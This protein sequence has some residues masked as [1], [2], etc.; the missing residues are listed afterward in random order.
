MTA[1]SSPIVDPEFSKLIPPLTPE[2]IS[3]LA[4]SLLEDGCRDPLVVWDEKC[5]LLDGHN[6]LRLCQKHGIEYQVARLSFSDRAAA[7]TWIIRNQLG[8][9]NL[10][11]DA[12]SYLRGLLYNREKKAVG[13]PKGTILDQN[14]PISTAERLAKEH[15]VSA[16]TIKR[17]SQFAKAVETLKPHVADIE[18]RVMS[19]NIPDK[20]RIIEAAK[21]PE[22]AEKLLTEKVV[23]VSHN[24]GENE[25]YT[26]A[27]LVEAARKTMGGI[28]CDPASSKI[29]NQTIKAKTFY[30]KDNDGL[31][32]K[33][34]ARVWMNPP[35]AQPL[36]SQFSDALVKRFKSDEVKQACVLV[37]NATETEWFQTMLRVA[38]AACFLK[39]RVRFIDQEG[40][41]SGAPLQG[42]A[43][44]YLGGNIERF[45]TEWSPFGIVLLR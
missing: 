18:Q 15:G 40:N 29:A 32:Q 37:N 27:P 26:P 24:S 31:T 19:G 7:E 22:K 45:K 36:I 1:T 35:Y 14:D 30:T 38:S 33:W 4:N 12:A 9:R 39:G 10:S 5:I 17:D 6:R 44:L 21:T 2:E 11:P 41:P 28:D 3:L 20:Q 8:R 23:H 34:A 25:W 13:K 42:Q 16:P 43:M